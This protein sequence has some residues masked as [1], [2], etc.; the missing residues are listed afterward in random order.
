MRRAAGIAV[1]AVVAAGLAGVPAAS[2]GSGDQADSFAAASHSK[3]SATGRW[4]HENLSS[5]GDRD[6]FRFTMPTSGRALVTLGHLPG[7]YA[8]DVYGPDSTLLASSDQPGRRFEQVYRAF[9]AGDVF[10]RVSSS[11]RVKPSVNY[12]LKFRPLPDAMVIAEQRNVGDKP[13]YDIKGELLNNTAQW[14]EVAHL[15]VTWVDRS[16]NSVGTQDEGIIPG[17][18]GPHKRIQFSVEQS[19]PPAGTTGY[20]IS[21]A[22]RTTTRRTPHGL[23]LTP[24]KRSE[25]PTQRV[26]RGTVHNTSSRTMRGVYPTVIEYDRLGRAIA[27]GF[28]Q[29]SSLAPGATSDYTAAVNI[30]GLPHLNGIRQFATITKP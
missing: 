9:A 14:R 22:D 7:N 13:G 10:V 15:H 17:P 8:L 12:A 20:R 2:A 25:T 1:I 28:D 4:L 3:A 26:Y 18:I 23:V 6:W 21:I 27:F 29:I 16:G 5:S 30:K 24:G 19:Q 11:H